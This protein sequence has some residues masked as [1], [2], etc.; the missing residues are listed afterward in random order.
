LQPRLLDNNNNS[1]TQFLVM[2][3]LLFGQRARRRSAM[4]VGRVPSLGPHHREERATVA[5]GRGET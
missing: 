5:V 3:T 1:N 2:R 4:E